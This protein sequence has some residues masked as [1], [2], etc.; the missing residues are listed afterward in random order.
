MSNPYEDSTYDEIY[1]DGEP[2]PICGSDQEWERCAVCGGDGEIDVY[3]SDP[4]WYDEGDTE[5][6]DQCD[7]QGGWYMCLNN[8]SHPE[9]S[10]S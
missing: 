4:L 1:G 5:P 10:G 7:G 2:C 3:E 9:E 8:A 6:C